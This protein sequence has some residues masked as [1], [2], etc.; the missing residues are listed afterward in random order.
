[1][2]N[3]FTKKSFPLWL[4]IKY[5]SLVPVVTTTLNKWIYEIIRIGGQFSLGVILT[6][7]RLF[8]DSPACCRLSH[9]RPLRSP[10]NLN[11][12][13]RLR[14]PRSS[15]FTSLRA[16]LNC[17]SHINFVPAVLTT[18]WW[19]LLLLHRPRK[20]GELGSESGQKN[21]TVVPINALI[22]DR[23]RLSLVLLYCWQINRLCCPY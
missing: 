18:S 10:D 14:P 8:P 13:H 7:W 12:G 3:S 21:R 5:C 17:C 16:Y 11:W 2:R 4:H 22:R 20:V 23:C 6:V 19:P 1:M 15:H 9:W